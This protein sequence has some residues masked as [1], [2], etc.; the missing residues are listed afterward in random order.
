MPS[1]RH[2]RH[3]LPCK[4]NVASRT[5]CQK[6][7]TGSSAMSAQPS[8][9]RS[10]SNTCGNEKVKPPS[11]TLSSTLPHHALSHHCCT[12]GKACTL[13]CLMIWMI[14]PPQLSVSMMPAGMWSHASHLQQ[15]AQ[16]T[17]HRL[18][19]QQCSLQRRR[20]NRLREAAPLGQHSAAQVVQ[21]LQVRQCDWHASGVLT[22]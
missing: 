1:L 15:Q 10:A 16:R 7:R 17:R 4:S 20:Q 12:S 11:G 2:L 5:P 14:E 22:V 3:L 9:K 6:F 8:S 13:S 19:S 18:P 21:S